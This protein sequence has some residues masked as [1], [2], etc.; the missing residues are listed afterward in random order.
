MHLNPIKSRTCW[1]YH[2]EKVSKGTELPPCHAE[3]ISIVPLRKQ[4]LACYSDVEKVAF[5]SSLL[6]V[7]QQQTEWLSS[8]LMWWRTE[9]CSF[10]PGCLI[11]VKYLQKHLLL[12]IEVRSTALYVNTKL[13][14]EAQMKLLKTAKLQLLCRFLS[15]WQG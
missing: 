8:N 15:Y 7:Q 5:L 14:T 9:S 1:Q 11:K 6:S 4:I 10:P 3:V 12:K 13:K 2:A